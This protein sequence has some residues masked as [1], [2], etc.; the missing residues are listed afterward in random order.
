MNC[1]GI[2]PLIPPVARGE[3]SLTEW[4][5]VEAHLKHCAGC[6]AE[7]E[8]VDEEKMHSR[9]IAAW[10]QTLSGL[11]GSLAERSRHTAAGLT[12]LPARLGQRLRQ[13]VTGAVGAASRTAGTARAWAAAA[14]TG[15]RAASR[16][17]VA[18]SAALRALAAHHA[19]RLREGS[20]A[21][22]IGIGRVRGSLGP[23]LAS[24]SRGVVDGVDRGRAHVDR[25]ASRARAQA[26]RVTAASTSGLEALSRFKAVQVAGIALVVGLA[27]YAVLP[28]PILRPDPASDVT[29]AHPVPNRPEPPDGAGRR[30]S[31]PAPPRLAAPRSGAMVTTT[32][33]Q[34]PRS[35]GPHVVG[36]LTV[37]DRD[38]SEQEVTDLLTRSG[39]ARIGGRHDLSSTI[40]YAVIPS[41]GYRKFI[42]GLA[43]IGSWQ[44]EAER[45]PL[46]RGIRMAIRMAD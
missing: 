17:L 5:L 13:P 39:G 42:R 19:A 9:P 11:S 27:L 20:H 41:S 2:R 24:V 28:T 46:P 1:H 8:R 10:S 25:V 35:D 30:G 32:S 6:R 33:A 29:I 26:A 21:V 34:S 23:A 14:S 40:V 18:R 45:S 7:R 15:T 4:A 16:S 37:R 38:A 36:R 43:Q 3:A 44:V 31:E 22:S 12:A